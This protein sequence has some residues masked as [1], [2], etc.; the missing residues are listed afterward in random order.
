VRVFREVMLACNLVIIPTCPG[1]YDIWACGDTIKVLKQARGINRDIHF[2]KPVPAYFV[3]NQLIPDTMISAEV[4][5]ALNDFAEDVKLM[6]SHLT[7]LVAFKTSIS[8]GLGVSE[9][10][11]DGKP[12]WR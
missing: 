10:E 9:Y 2:E 11:P 7:S 12:A 3:L 4:E 6:N 1:Q 5:Q 8:N